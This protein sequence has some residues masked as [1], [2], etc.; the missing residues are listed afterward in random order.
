M[1]GNPA[2][3]A[4]TPTSSLSKTDSFKLYQDWVADALEK[5]RTSGFSTDTRLRPGCNVIEISGQMVRAP[6]R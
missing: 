2:E 3:E 1:E 5:E 4:P 6:A